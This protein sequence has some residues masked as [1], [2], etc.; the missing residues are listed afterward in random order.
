VK[1]ERGISG[2]SRYLHLQLLEGP[3]VQRVPVVH[4]LLRRIGRAEVVQ[5][6]DPR[7]EMVHDLRNKDAIAGDGKP[8]LTCAGAIGGEVFG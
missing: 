7:S 2:R 8:R 6:D 3:L 1:E 4:L 5:V